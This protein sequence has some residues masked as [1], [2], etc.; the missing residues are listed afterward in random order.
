M[1]IKNKLVGAGIAV[2]ILFGMGATVNAAEPSLNIEQRQIQGLPRYYSTNEY[3][4]A[5]ESGNPNNVGINS[6]YNEVNYMTNNWGN[7]FVTHW[8][9]SGG[10]VI[11]VAPSGYISWGAGQYA[12][13][14]SYAQVELARTNNPAVFKQDYVSYVTLLRQLAKEAGI[15]TQLDGNGRGIKTHEW[16]TYQLG[17]T[18]HTD[19]Y[20]YLASMGI[21]RAQFA[22]DIAYGIDGT[23]SNSTVVPV[24]PKPVPTG[25]VK[26]EAYNV[27]Q[28][29]DVN[30]L[31][32][33]TAQTA[34]STA[35]G[36][37]NAGQTFN[38]TRIARTGQNVGGYTTW[39]EVD[40]RGW[41]SGAYVTPVTTS[42]P[43]AKPVSNLKGSNLPNSGY[44]TV[45][46]NTNI[47]S[48]AGLGNGIVGMY[49]AGQ[50][51]HYDSKFE[52][53]GYVWLSYISYSG[54]RRYVAV[55]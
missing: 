3:V 55:V 13:G 49:A 42:K 41:V 33:R 40:G 18:D 36:S 47:R 6:L 48:G 52:A 16:I 27:R 26:V 34:N 17:G 38:A 14:R 50:G 20:S 15:P 25:A 21:S 54:Q 46:S 45:Q 19:P 7:A 4:V 53:D 44:Y 2:A 31:N 35:I 37:M 29:V 30:G 43:V 5:H 24:T 12:N 11:Q 8:V 9:G 32:V 39:F 1:S 28:S 10:K 51:F 22:K 23:S